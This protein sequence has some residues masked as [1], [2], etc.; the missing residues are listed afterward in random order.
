[1]KI[2]DVILTPSYSGFYFD[3]QKAIKANNAKVDGFNLVGIPMTLG[4]DKIRIP[5]EA[6][7]VG[8]L[9]EDDSIAYG[10]CAAVQYSGAGGRDPLF[11]AK[12]FIP[13][14]EKHLVEKLI[15]LDVS[16]FRKNAEMFDKLEINGKRIHTAIRYGLTSIIKCDCFNNRLT[17]AE[18]IRKEYEIDENFYEPYSCFYAKW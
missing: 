16:E 14:I 3:D 8:L 7:S 12:D 2:K 10:D 17:I 18:V 9:L 13:Y 6:I 4:F 11:L 1:M 5:G 15:G